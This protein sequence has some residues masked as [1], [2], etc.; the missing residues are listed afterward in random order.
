MIDRCAHV[1]NRCLCCQLVS[2]QARYVSF[3][4]LSLLRFSTDDA[5]L[6]MT[7]NLSFS[8][9]LDV[10]A[11]YPRHRNG[12]RHCLLLDLLVY[13]PDTLWIELLVIPS[14]RSDKH[15]CMQAPSGSHA[16]LSL[17]QARS[18]RWLSRLSSFCF[19][20]IWQSRNWQGCHWHSWIRTCFW[21]RVQRGTP[22][23][24]LWEGE[25]INNRQTDTFY[26]KAF[27]TV[28]ATVAWRSRLFLLW[29]KTEIFGE[30]KEKLHRRDFR[31][32]NHN[33]LY[34]E[35]MKHDTPFS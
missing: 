31:K 25:G 3:P 24:D 13:Q 27:N 32:E 10:A 34:E 15:I 1:S 19:S 17:L 33:L 6:S 11:P 16:F 35:R 12:S 28:S 4:S 22:V 5:W 18:S 26:W 30:L 23:A 21:E 9:F 7:P 2:R 14:I 20:L 29:E 8:P